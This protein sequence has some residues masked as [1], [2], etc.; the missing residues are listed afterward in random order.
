[1]SALYFILFLG[2]LIFFHELGHFLAARAV[3]VTVLRFSIGFGPKILGFKH[4]GTEYW[5]SAVPLG[6]YV[7]FLGDDPENLPSGFEAAKGFLTTAIW[8]RVVIVLAGPMFNLVLPLLVFLPTFLAKSE[9]PPSVLGTV[10][11]GGPAW[12]AGLRGGDRVVEMDGQPV[13]YFWELQAIIGAHPAQ[14]VAVTV[15][16]HGE[17]KQLT[18]TPAAVPD[19]ILK[20][21][22]FTSE[23]G[24]IEVTLEATRPVVMV[25]GGGPAAAAGMKDFDAVLAVDGRE[26]ASFEEVRDALAAAST[27]AVRVVVAPTSLESAEPG[28]SREVVIG[29]LA[30]AGIGAGV[31]DGATV[32]SELESDSPADRAG[33]KV[34]DRIVQVDGRDVAGWLFMVQD[35]EREPEAAHAVRVERA[36]GTV[37]LTLSLVNPRWAPGAAVPKYA[38][39]AASRRAVV[40]PDSIPNDARLR[41][42]LDRSLARTKKVFIVTVGGLAGLVTGH[43]SVKEMGGPIMI[44]HIAST[45]GQRGWAD[46]FDALAWLSMSLGVLNLLPV[47][48]LDGGHLVLFG[49]EAVR[50]K[51][52]G[53][54]GRQIATYFG[55][56]L[57]LMLMAIVFVNDIDR[58]WGPLSNM[59]SSK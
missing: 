20:E 37:D 23:S 32:V 44:Y 25:V 57:L 54:R 55:L 26:P 47:P 51:P 46:F 24:Q 12:V 6:G 14:P 31:T 34:G 4:H 48:V 49:I 11:R 19:P 17:R 7:K 53:L 22:G 42:A 10:A 59:G 50:R 8:R 35:L 16:R 40:T 3:G 56:A 39:G 1:M 52:V 45:A 58:M 41:F 30:D 21:V 43:V 36:G 5:L 2:G 9:L 18:V 29:P 28:P 27:R 13:S 15:D 38:F 33:L